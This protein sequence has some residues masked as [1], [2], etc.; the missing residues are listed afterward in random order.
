[1]PLTFSV[2]HNPISAAVGDFNHDNISDLIIASSADNTV[3]I[4]VG[5]GQN[6]INYLLYHLVGN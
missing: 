6:G 2:G 1:V 4:F 3:T 5:N